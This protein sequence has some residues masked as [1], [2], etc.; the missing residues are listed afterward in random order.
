VIVAG[1]E[2]HELAAVAEG[3]V[4]DSGL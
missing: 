3:L 2:D 4:I 1:F